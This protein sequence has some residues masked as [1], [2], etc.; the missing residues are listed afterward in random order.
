MRHF[1]FCENV[2]MVDPNHY[3]LHGTPPCIQQYHPLVVLSILCCGGG[4]RTRD[5]QVLS[6]GFDYSKCRTIPPSFQIGEDAS[7]I[8]S[9][10]SFS[11]HSSRENLSA[12]CPR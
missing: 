10:P 7:I 5:L 1:F 2:R 8:V 6:V 4:I 11:F 12:Y 9:E 3:L